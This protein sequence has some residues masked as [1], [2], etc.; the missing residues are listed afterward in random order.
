M[1]NKK[2]LEVVE[3]KPASMDEVD[4]GSTRWDMEFEFMKWYQGLTRKR[5]RRLSAKALMGELVN[6]LWPLV[7]KYH[8]RARK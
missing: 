4:L 2:R 7:K 8:R 6:R 3:V 5:A 1:K